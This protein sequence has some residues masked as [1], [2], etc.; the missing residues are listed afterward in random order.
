MDQVDD[1][2]K[3]YID[4]AITSYDTAPTEDVVGN[5]L[6]SYMQTRS[7]EKYYKSSNLVADAMRAYPTVNWR[8]LFM[9]KTRLEGK[10]EL[11][12]NNETTWPIQEEGRKD[13]K[14]AL[15]QEHGKSFMHLAE[16]TGDQE[17]VNS[18]PDFRDYLS[19]IIN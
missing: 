14:D 18:F 12:F 15:A 16:W 6:N 9:Q 3:I 5:A 10:S 13:A 7:I 11:E 17:L 2:S 8:N 19:S 4:I 1:L